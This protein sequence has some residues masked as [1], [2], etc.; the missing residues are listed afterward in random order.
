MISAFGNY[1]ITLTRK[2][3]I[4]L[5]EAVIFCTAHAVD[6]DG[7]VFVQSYTLKRQ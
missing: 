5:R 3:T 1:N 2:D 4:Y 6:E 7:F